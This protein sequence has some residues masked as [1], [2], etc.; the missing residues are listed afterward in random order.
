MVP[1]QLS[2]QVLT[3]LYCDPMEFVQ[4]PVAQ[5]PD[6]DKSQRILPYILNFERNIPYSLEKQ[7]AYLNSH[8]SLH[9]IVQP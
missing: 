7:S 2:P 4:Q 1:L 9:G 3:E 5:I 8:E 6:L